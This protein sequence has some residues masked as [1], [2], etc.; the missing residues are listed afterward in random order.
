[1]LTIPLQW[2]ERWFR[3]PDGPVLLSTHRGCGREFVAE[4]T[5]G[6]YGDRVAGGDLGALTTSQPSIRRQG[7]S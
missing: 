2:A 1:M 3:A 6:H 5:C 7:E 4:F